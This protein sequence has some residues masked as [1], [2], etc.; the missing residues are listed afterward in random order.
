MRYLHDASDARDSALKQC[1]VAAYN[2]KQPKLIFAKLR[3]LVSRDPSPVPREPQA[4]D[5]EVD[6]ESHH[7]EGPSW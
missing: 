2:L 7:H 6:A 1:L 4:V 5:A 3:H